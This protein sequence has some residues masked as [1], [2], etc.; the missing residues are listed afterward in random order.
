MFYVDTEPNL[1]EMQSSGITQGQEL[2]SQFYDRFE[3]KLQYL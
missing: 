2:V 3:W 1:D